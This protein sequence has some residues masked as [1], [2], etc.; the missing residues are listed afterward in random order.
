VF[1]KK[2]IVISLLLLTISFADDY[3]DTAEATL[4][5][6]TVYNSDNSVFAGTINSNTDTDWFDINVT[7]DFQDLERTSLVIRIKGANITDSNITVAVFDATGANTI[8]QPAVNKI[9]NHK[10]ADYLI[11]RLSNEVIVT[12]D[13]VTVRVTADKSVDYNISFGAEQFAEPSIPFVNF[14]SDVLDRNTTFDFQNPRGKIETSDGPNSI[15]MYQW[16]FG[17]GTPPILKYSN[18][19]DDIKV[20]H[21]YSHCGVFPVKLDIWNSYENKNETKIKDDEAGYKN[22]Q[23]CDKPLILSSAIKNNDTNP[24]VVTEANITEI[25]NFSVDADY[26]PTQLP[27]KYEWDFGNG[28][29]SSE[30]NTSYYYTI[31]GNYTI[32]L[33]V[34]GANDN[35]ETILEWNLTIVDK[36]IDYHS[37]FV[38]EATLIKTNKPIKGKFHNVVIDKPNHPETYDIDWLEV[39]TTGATG[40]LV[41]RIEDISNCI[42]K[43]AVF[44][45]DLSYQ[46]P[47]FTK[48]WDSNETDYFMVKIQ[49][50][51]YINGLKLKI[52]DVSNKKDGNYTL[53]IGT[54]RFEETRVPYADFSWTY[55]EVTNSVIFNSDLSESQLD[56]VKTYKWDF[57]DST[58]TNGWIDKDRTTKHTLNEINPIHKYE[59]CF[60]ANV[61]LTVGDS[62]GNTDTLIQVVPNCTRPNLTA[63]ISKTQLKI[64]DVLEL[65]ATGDYL[66]PLTYIWDFGDGTFS[67]QDA[68]VTHQFN[69]G[70]Y[71]ITCTA[72]GT[73]K[74]SVISQIFSIVVTEAE[75]AKII[76]LNPL[77]NEYNDKIFNFSPTITNEDGGIKSY[78]WSINGNKFSS[79]KE[80]SYQFQSCKDYNISLTTINDYDKLSTYSMII[81]PCSS[82]PYINID[83]FPINNNKIETK[84]FFES[85]LINGINSTYKWDFGDGTI[86]YNQNATHIYN[87][88]G[89]YKISLVIMDNNGEEYRQEFTLIVDDPEPIDKIDNIPIPDENKVITEFELTLFNNSYNNGWNLISNPISERINTKIKFPNASVI[90]IYKDFKW[91]QNPLEISQGIGIW[92]KNSKREIINFEGSTYST[93]ILNSNNIKTGWNLNGTGDELV[94]EKNIF[95]YIDVIWKYDSET[96]QWIKNPKVIERGLGFWIKK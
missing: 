16:D 58:K 91:Q 30:Q 85:K 2:I 52:T 34:S 45:N 59:K 42:P 21:N 6:N 38:N 44:D 49:Q 27:L 62:Y 31:D 83:N 60:N 48:T 37:D 29:T 81:S 64:Y 51:D 8:N 23:V 77:R 40:E 56:Y 50:S 39:D 53:S 95:N 82:K 25:L 89:T 5:D 94:V 1:L 84:L 20:S 33:K 86:S 24:I 88:G 3:P 13:I 79:E 46:R 70:D 17:D 78:Q 35:A 90:Y 12:G 26:I 72:T 41:L 4:T 80:V 93:D 73:D 28:D 69:I 71:N 74:K 68:N 32:I 7:N 22:I 96:N 61:N 10:E 9:F 67:N 36:L 54:P 18:S 55:D 11:F 15:K 63:S 14:Y 43:V 76:S 47:K 19:V 57:N 87:I 92:V 66:T 65:N 75:P